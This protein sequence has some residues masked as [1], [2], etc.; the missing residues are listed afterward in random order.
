MLQ[1][2]QEVNASP[3]AMAMRFGSKLNWMRQ[4]ES[5]K[6]DQSVRYAGWLSSSA[7]CKP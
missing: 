7:I 1:A 2:L 4:L 5:W 3:L 6:G